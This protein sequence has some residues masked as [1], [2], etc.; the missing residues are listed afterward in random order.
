M[1]ETNDTSDSKY[2]GKTN[3]IPLEV[4]LSL[5]PPNQC[6][7][8]PAVRLF[9]C[10]YEAYPCMCY[11]YSQEESAYI[12]ATSVMEYIQKELK[13]DISNDFIMRGYDYKAKKQYISSRVCDLGNGIMIDIDSYFVFDLENP[14]K[15][16]SDASDDGF[17]VV[18][19]LHLYYL[20][21]NDAFVQ[22]LSN[23]FSKMMVFTSKSCTLEM[24]C[25]NQ[26]GYYL[27]SITIKKPMI[28]DLALHYGQS[29]VATHVVKSSRTSTKQKAE[30]SYCFT[31]FPARVR[32]NSI[33]LNF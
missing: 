31:A 3:G 12:H 13:H 22:E 17:I 8:L 5:A 33:A 14:N 11:C 9:I 7:G 32:S 27:S 18:S 2:I 16:Q 23:Q 30:A 19:Q 10:R 28:S 25:C 29:F 26:Q 1:T 21:Q 20:P 15:Y 4:A 24:V 6:E